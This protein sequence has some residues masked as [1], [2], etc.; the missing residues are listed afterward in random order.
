MDNTQFSKQKNFC[1]FGGHFAT[2]NNY[3]CQILGGIYNLLK[4]SSVL[5]TNSHSFSPSKVFRCV[6]FVI[7]KTQLASHLQIRLHSTMGV[8]TPHIPAAADFKRPCG[9][10]EL[11]T[12]N[13]PP[14]W[15]SKVSDGQKI[16]QAQLTW[17]PHIPQ[18]QC[19]GFCNQLD[20]PTILTIVWQLQQQLVTTTTITI[21]IDK[22]QPESPGPI[23]SSSM[24][25]SRFQ[26]DVLATI[27]SNY[28]YQFNDWQ[29][30]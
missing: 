24:L 26:F 7:H 4:V 20:I 11:C 23:P 2:S 16:G 1:E 17:E 21:L 5:L 22:V 27:T 30:Q 14:N 13:K 3:L 6:T 25:Q 18:L 15:Q 10:S 8:F 28:S 29:L 12:L 9:P 19:L